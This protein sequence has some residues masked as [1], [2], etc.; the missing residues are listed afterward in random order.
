[1]LFV[2]V[3]SSLQNLAPT[4]GFSNIFHFDDFQKIKYF[5]SFSSFPLN[6]PRGC[7]FADPK[8]TKIHNNKN[9]MIC[10]NRRSRSGGVAILGFGLPMLHGDRFF[11]WS[12][13][14]VGTPKM[15]SSTP[16]QREF[17]FFHFFNTSPARSSKIMK[18]MLY[19]H[20]VGVTFSRILHC[21]NEF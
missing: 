1:M 2:V 9:L 14:S 10:K 12:P 11:L 18:M 6:S 7:Q 20:C 21:S 3:T 4:N 19:N 5:W 17:D 16:P 8:S 13:C 15:H